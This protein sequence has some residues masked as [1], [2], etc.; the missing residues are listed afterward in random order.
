M[1]LFLISVQTLFLKYCKLR[2]A[3]KVSLDGHLRTFTVFNGYKTFI[4]FDF[5]CGIGKTGVSDML[6]VSQQ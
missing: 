6:E 3:S 1:A 4:R 2:D 5:P